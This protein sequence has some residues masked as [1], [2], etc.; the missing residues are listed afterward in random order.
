MLASLYHPD[1][2]Q[3]NFNVNQ[4]VSDPT[5][6]HSLRSNTTNTPSPQNWCAVPIYTTLMS[7]ALC[8]VQ[9]PKLYTLEFF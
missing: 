3:Y 1:L 7:T 4:D 2:I 9:E 5:Q 6:Y 8:P